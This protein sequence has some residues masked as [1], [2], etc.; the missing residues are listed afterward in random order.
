MRLCVILGDKNTKAT[1]GS[2]GLPA[3]RYAVIAYD[4]LL[5]VLWCHVRTVAMWKGEKDDMPNDLC[6]HI[7]QMRFSRG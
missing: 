2:A 7:F 5:A 4:A 3:I 1:T 6:E